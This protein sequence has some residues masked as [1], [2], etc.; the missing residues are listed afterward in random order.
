MMHAMTPASC[1]IA[2][3]GAMYSA[4]GSGPSGC[5]HGSTARTLSQKGWKSVTRS[6][7]TCMFPAGS[8]VTGPPPRGTAS[9]IFVLHARPACPL[10]RMAH[11][12]QM[13]LR[14]EH[15]SVSVPSISSRTLIRPSKT[16]AESSISRSYSWK[17]ASGLSTSGSK[18]LTLS[19]T[20]INTL[21]PAA[22]TR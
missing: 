13:A 21:S 17:R 22:P 2:S 9:D 6:F 3:F 5:S 10:I 18:R 14:Q 1:S 8:T 15:R 19:V 11:E 20:C 16:V 4:S 12:P 7:M